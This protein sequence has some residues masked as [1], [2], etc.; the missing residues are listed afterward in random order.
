VKVNVG[1]SFTWKNLYV[2]VSANS[3]TN[4]TTWKSRKN[5]A[6]GNMTLT[7]GSGETGVKEDTSNTDSLSDG[8][9]ID[10]SVTTD[11]GTNAL[12]AQVVSTLLISTSGAWLVCGSAVGLAQ[13]FGTTAYNG[14][15]T[16]CG[17]AATSESDV[18][19]LPRFDYSLKNLGAYVSA[20]T[21]NGTSTLTFRDNQSD[22]ALAV[23]WGSSE[24]GW[25]SDTDSVGITGGTDY[26]NYKLATG[27]TSGIL[28][29][30]GVSMLGYIVSSITGSASITL[31]AST[32]S[33]AGTVKIAGAFSQ[34]LADIALSST[35]G[36]VLVQGVLSSLLADILLE[37][38]ASQLSPISGVLS[39]TL[40]DAVLASAGAVALKGTSSLLLD[41]FGQSFAGKVLVKGNSGI[42]LADLTPSS[43]GKVLVSGLG[44]IQLG[45]LILAG[46]A[47]GKVLVSGNAAVALQDLLTSTAGKVLVAGA[48]S[49][50]LADL[51][52]LASGGA[53]PDIDEIILLLNGRICKK[54]TDTIYIML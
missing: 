36:K 7:F 18:R 49:I 12:T 11:T 26:V 31:D 34:A 16:H 32:L 17:T 19:M 37:S 50:P 54:I 1:G 27:G 48:A 5:G 28:T 6:D 15:M 22:S 43:A 33:S 51:L 52:M 53:P 20:N 25:K 40:G 47:A 21:V 41:P 30:Y 29:L 13:A 3:R 35:S 45:D 10:L 8:D 23:S 14:L 4:N 38:A 24:S 46:G 2:Y 44:P 42:T 9:D 39:V